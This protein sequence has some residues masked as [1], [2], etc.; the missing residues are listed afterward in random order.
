MA[1]YLCPST[2][3]HPTRKWRFDYAWPDVKIALEIQGG[4]FRGGRHARP[5]GYVKDMEKMNNAQL[6]GWRVFQVLPS[7]LTSGIATELLKE[8]FDGRVSEGSGSSGESSS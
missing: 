6:L 8:V 7:D 2:S 4:I 5:A 3:F 1:G